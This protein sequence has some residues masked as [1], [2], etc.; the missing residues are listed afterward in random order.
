MR[1]HSY[2][3]STPKVKPAVTSFTAPCGCDLK[4]VLTHSAKTLAGC[5]QRVLHSDV[6]ALTDVTQRKWLHTLYLC[7]NDRMTFL[8]EKCAP[9]FDVMVRKDVTLQKWFFL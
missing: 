3:V 7:E 2:D 5:S 1:R 9:G 8:L 6:K 4:E